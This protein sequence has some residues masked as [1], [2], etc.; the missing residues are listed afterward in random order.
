MPLSWPKLTVKCHTGTTSAVL[1]DL[2]VK[3]VIY[4][5]AENTYAPVEVTMPNGQIRM[6][7]KYPTSYNQDEINYTGWITI[8]DTANKN[9]YI[10]KTYDMKDYIQYSKFGTG[11]HTIEV[12][13]KG[14]GN[15]AAMFYGSYAAFDEK[16]MVIK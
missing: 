9:A 10:G 6:R 2:I 4:Y 13:C 1:K 8:Y 3:L 5:D 16:T 12:Q 7:I 11:D 15:C 14:N